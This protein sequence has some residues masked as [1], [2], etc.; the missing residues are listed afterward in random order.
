MAMDLSLA[1][2]DRQLIKVYFRNK[3]R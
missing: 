2:V 1:I 3:Y